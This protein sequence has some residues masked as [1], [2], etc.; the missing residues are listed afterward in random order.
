VAVDPTTD[1]RKAALKNQHGVQLME[2]GK[3]EGAQ[4]LPE[5]RS[6]AVE[7]E[8]LFAR[9]ESHFDLLRRVIPIENLTYEDFSRS[10]QV[11]VN[12]KAHRFQAD[13]ELVGQ[14]IERFV[15]FLDRLSRHGDFKHGA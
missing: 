13:S 1:V 15:S 4:T 3:F 11:P 7:S 5:D 9:S 2:A 6:T 14:G 10:Y 8:H 12:S